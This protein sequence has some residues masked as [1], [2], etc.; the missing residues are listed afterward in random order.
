VS[1]ILGGTVVNLLEKDERDAGAY[2]PQCTDCAAGVSHG[3]AGIG[4]ALRY[5]F[6]TLP[7][8]I[9]RALLTGILLAGVIGAIVPDDFF[10]SVLGGGLLAMLVMMAVGIPVYV[11][12][13]A[14]VPIAAALI[15]KGVSPGAALVFLMTGPATNAATILTVSRIMGRRTAVIYLVTVAACALAGGVLLDAIFKA[16][17]FPEAAGHARMLPG[18]LK[19]GSAFVLSAVVIGSFF[20]LP[21]DRA[22]AEKMEKEGGMKLKIEGMSCEHCVNSVTK[23]LLESRGVE[24]ALVDLKKGEAVVKGGDLD[25]SLLKEAVESLGYKVTGYDDPGA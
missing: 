21:K 17:A 22:A 6:H 23:A 19:T 1:G 14:S 8:D 16:G 12:A 24:S 13:T 3:S 5:G 18:W 10:A 2:V 9:N 7:S 4:G 25:F 11:C 15:A 20:R